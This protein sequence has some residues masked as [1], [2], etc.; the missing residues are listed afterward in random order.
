MSPDISALLHLLPRAYRRL[1]NALLVVETEMTAGEAD[2]V[3]GDQA[4]TWRQC[5]AIL[6]R[7]IDATLE[8]FVPLA[9]EEVDDAS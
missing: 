1:V 5:R 2:E 4:E 8:P 9:S 3:D 6:H 7:A